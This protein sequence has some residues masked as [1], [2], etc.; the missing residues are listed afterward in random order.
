[1][2]TFESCILATGA[3]ERVNQSERTKGSQSARKI[4]DGSC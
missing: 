3:K 4:E 2:R 1:M